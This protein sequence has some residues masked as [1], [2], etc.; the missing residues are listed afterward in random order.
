MGSIYAGKRNGTT[1][2][3]YQEARRVKVD[4]LRSGKTKGSGKSTVRTKVTYLGTR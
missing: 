1:Y 3:V 2:Y 4:P